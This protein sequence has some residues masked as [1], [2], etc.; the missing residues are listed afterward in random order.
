MKIGHAILD[1]LRDDRDYPFAKGSHWSRNTRLASTS[2]YVRVRRAGGSIEDAEAASEQ[3]VAVMD[4]ARDAV[5][6]TDARYAYAI[7]LVLHALDDP[8]ER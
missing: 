3:T 1:T 2:V 6:G 8:L 7:R 4:A 5:K